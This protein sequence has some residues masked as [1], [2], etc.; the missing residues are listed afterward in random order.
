MRLRGRGVLL[1]PALLLAAPE[2]ELVR[3]EPF[4]YR[5]VGTL[6]AGWKRSPD[7]KLVFAYSVDGVPHAYVHLV[8]ERLRGEVDVAAQVKRRAP[9]YRFPGVPAP[10]RESVRETV[11]AGLPAVLY[12]H[13]AEIKGVRCRRQVTALF[14]KSVW[15]ELIETS[16]GRAAEEER[17]CA[18]GLHLFRHGFQLLVAPLAEAEAKETKEAEIASPALGYTIL[19]PLGF[20]RLPVDTGQDPGCRVAFEARAGHPHRHILVRLFEYGVRTQFEPPKWMDIFF[21]GFGI[22]NRDAQR[23]AVEAPTIRGARQAV[24]EEFTGQRDE[25]TVRTLMVLMQAESGRVLAL[26]IRTLEG[27]ESDFADAIQRIL[28]GLELR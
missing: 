24:A 4:N 12:E 27:T 23:K 14:A 21:T 20:T 15:Y 18:L 26:R 17:R 10:A 1:L 5:I 28:A 9:H 8:R 3:E 2:K 7:R 19:K 22:D 11:W 6:P 25:R 13:E 16:Y